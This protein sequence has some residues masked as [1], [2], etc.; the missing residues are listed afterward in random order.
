MVGSAS[1][2]AAASGDQQ[3]AASNA[4]VAGIFIHA[5][6]ETVMR[7]DVSPA[8]LFAHVDGEFGMLATGALIT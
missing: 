3:P 4:E 7:H 2:A 1:R 6:A 8:H 5:L